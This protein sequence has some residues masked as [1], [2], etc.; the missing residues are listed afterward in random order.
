MRVLLEFLVPSVKD[1]EESD[2][3]AEVLRI[4][5]NLQQRL[6]AGT[7]PFAT[8]ATEQ[9]RDLCPVI[10]GQRRDPASD[11]PRSEASWR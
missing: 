10:P 9:T 3:G 1:A 4:A 5:S 7:A 2:L 11:R 6:G 8:G